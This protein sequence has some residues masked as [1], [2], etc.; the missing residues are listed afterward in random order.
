VRGHALRLEDAEALGVVRA[1]GGKVA[2]E[3][4]QFAEGVVDAMGVLEA[5]AGGD[6]G[7]VRVGVHM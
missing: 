6:L 4:V 7:D 5:L 1:C 3:A 2:F